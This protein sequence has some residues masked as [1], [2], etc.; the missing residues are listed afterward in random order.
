MD[1]TVW[2]WVTVAVILLTGEILSPGMFMLP[3]GV[4]AVAAATASAMGAS[5]GWQWIAFVSVSSV[6]MVALQRWLARRRKR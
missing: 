2:V 1:L 3:F 4:G 6:L 5:P